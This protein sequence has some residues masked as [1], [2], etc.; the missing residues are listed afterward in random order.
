M[1]RA[2][3]LL[4][5]TL[6]ALSPFGDAAPEPTMPAHR[7]PWRGPS[8]KIPKP[9]RYF[10]GRQGRKLTRRLRMQLGKNP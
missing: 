8:W 10:G 6:A 3:V 2:N 5:A 9:R 1:N 7:A 4:A